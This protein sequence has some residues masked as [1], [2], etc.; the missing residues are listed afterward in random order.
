[1]RKIPK[2]TLIAKDVFLECISTV[3]NLLLKQNYEK[4]QDLVEAAAQD[5]D[6]KFPLLEIYQIP[7]NLTVLGSIGK[8][9]MKSVYTYRMVKDGM[10]GNTFYNT[11]K[12]SAPYGKCP[13]CS[14]RFVETLD[15]Y[16]PKSL[17]PILSVVPVNLIPSCSSCNTGK[18]ISFPTNSIEQTF[19]PYYD[20]IQDES[21]IKATL[22]PYDPFGFNYFVECPDSWE[23]IKKDR[24]NNHFSS[25]KLNT[26]FTAHANEE[27]RGAKDHMKTLFN[28]HP[29][30]LIKH[31]DGAFRSRRDQL[32]INSW[33]A[34]MY[35]CLLKD[36][37]FVQG[38]VL[39]F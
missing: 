38:G 16:L 10:P 18:K 20:D 25:F 2:P 31:L 36:N 27:F 3:G 1:M 7:R 5:F 37:W 39:T 35:Y 26:L 28:L 21:W 34:V 14:V 29:D 17:Y 6:N 24:A 4:C 23:Q 32:G 15:H 22:L 11:L 19:H 9:E 13:L 30:E 33:Q 12:N 8:E